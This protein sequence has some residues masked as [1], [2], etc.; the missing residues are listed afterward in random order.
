MKAIKAAYLKQVS[1]STPVNRAIATSVQ[2]Y[3]TPFISLGFRLPRGGIGGSDEASEMEIRVK[4][5]WHRG[6]PRGRCG[7]MNLLNQRSLLQ[8]F[9]TL[10]RGLVYL[11]T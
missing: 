7:G 10:Q 9:G 4:I 6:L 2:F 3:D 1:A 11:S 8:N 5:F